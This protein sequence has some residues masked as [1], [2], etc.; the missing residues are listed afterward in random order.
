SGDGDV[1][2]LFRVAVAETRVIPHT[3]K[4]LLS[5]R[6]EADRRVTVTARTAGVLTELRVRRGSVGK[7][8][9]VLAILSD[10]SRE[11]QV[12]QAQTVVT[13]RRTEY[14]A[15]KELIAK[16][17]MPRLEGVNLESRLASAEA[18]LA[19]AEAE[20]DRG[21]IRAPWS[22]VVSDI[23]VEVGKAALSF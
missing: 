2:K 15:K 7:T 16:G 20:R 4:L 10:E 6:T 22:G 3:R 17:M 14:E 8:R 5:G 18:A 12:S 19:A 9:D 13:Q 11:A 21:V 23:G 1:K